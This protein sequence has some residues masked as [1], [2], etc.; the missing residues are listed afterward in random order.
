MAQS[1]SARYLY[2]STKPSNAEVVSS[3]LTWSTQL[4]GREKGF[5]GTWRRSGWRRT[6]VRE[7]IMRLWRQRG[8]A[9]VGTARPGK[10]LCGAHREGR[11]LS[12]TCVCLCL[13][14]LYALE[15]TGF[16][17]RC[18][19]TETNVFL[20][21][22]ACEWEIAGNKVYFTAC[23]FIQSANKMLDWCCCCNSMVITYHISLFGGD[24]LCNC[25]LP[26]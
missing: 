19:C 22:A 10:R 25:S 16:V 3:S 7:K 14:D 18:P 2:S 13:Q 5:F 9:G 11:C 21:R 12:A 24:S 23:C 26:G 15:G 8:P 4:F 6:K 1:V 17:T 20:L